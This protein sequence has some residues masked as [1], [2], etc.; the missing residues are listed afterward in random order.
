MG[1]LLS[2]SDLLLIEISTVFLR[3]VTP[4][5]NTLGISWGGQV[6]LVV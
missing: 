2:E 5:S 3:V 4:M 6:C 1:Q